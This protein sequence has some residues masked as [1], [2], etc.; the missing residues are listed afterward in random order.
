ML[1]HTFFPCLSLLLM[2]ERE[3]W[4]IHCFSVRGTIDRWRRL[5]IPYGR[6]LFSISIQ[7][8]FSL[9]VSLSLFLLL[10]RPR[11]VNRHEVFSCYLQKYLIVPF[12]LSSVL[13]SIFNFGNYCNCYLIC[14][15]CHGTLHMYVLLHCGKRYRFKTLCFSWSSRVDVIVRR[16]IIMCMCV[17]MP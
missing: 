13:Y 7:L 3:C 8:L 14:I 6:P 9:M 4:S 5:T 15:V 16:F 12:S 2:Y 10:S 1:E 11:L 17:N